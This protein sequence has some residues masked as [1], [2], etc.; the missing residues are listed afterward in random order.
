MK[1]ANVNP[2]DKNPDQSR[3][4]EQSRGIVG[5]TIRCVRAERLKNGHGSCRHAHACRSRMRLSGF[6]INTHMK[7]FLR[8]LRMRAMHVGISKSA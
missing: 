1:N 3:V 2:H 7:L 6:T 5:T 8:V 4:R